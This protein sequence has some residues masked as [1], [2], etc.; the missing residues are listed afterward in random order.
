M[1]GYLS[2]AYTRLP[3]IS[4][5]TSLIGIGPERLEGPLCRDSHSPQLE[6]VLACGCDFH[7]L[8]FV[9]E[10]A[11]RLAR[12][13]I[14]GFPPNRIRPQWNSGEIAG[15]IRDDMVGL[16]PRLGEGLPG[17]NSHYTQSYRYVVN[18][19]NSPGTSIHDSECRIGEANRHRLTSRI[20][21]KF[22]LDPFRTADNK[23]KDNNCSN[24]NRS[25]GNQ[26]LSL[27]CHFFCHLLLFR[28]FPHLIQH[29]AHGL[30]IAAYPLRNPC[31]Q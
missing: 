19:F 12:L 15:I 26:Q 4:S 5:E 25:Y 17:Y 11:N 24:K 22:G 10:P 13:Q 23:S 14:G 31:A 8:E 9:R 20:V 21:L 27:L 30:P 16:I 29:P 6:L 3:L 2:G 7:D 1:L 18:A 28:F